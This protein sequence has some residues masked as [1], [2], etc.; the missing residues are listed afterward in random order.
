MAEKMRVL[1]QEGAFDESLARTVF[2]LSKSYS[3]DPF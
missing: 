2:A 1:A 3:A